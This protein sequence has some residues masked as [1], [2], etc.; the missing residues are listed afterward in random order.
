MI[1]RGAESHPM[2]SF[3]AR[4]PPDPAGDSDALEVLLGSVTCTLHSCG[5][6]EFG[7]GWAIPERALEYHVAY[8]A[9]AGELAVQFDDEE[10]MRIVRPGEVV[11]AGPRERH[12]VLNGGPTPVRL[13]TVH[14]TARIHD[15]VDMPAVYGLARQSR[16]A[17]ADAERIEGIVRQMIDDLDDAAPGSALAANAD[18]GR[19][20]AALWRATVGAAEERTPLA[21]SKARD[22]VRLAPV[23]RVI[24]ERY[25]ERPTVADL[26]GIVHLEPDHFATVFKRVTGTSP[27]AYVAAHRLQRVRTLLAAT[28][29]PIRSIAA[30]TG[31]SDPFY[32]SRAFR[33]AYGMTPT[34][35]RKSRNRPDLP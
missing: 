2:R 25:A 14:F 22:L 10:A 15:V 23:F 19:F 11:L 5:W 30:R 7:R 33:R 28:D 29:E 16:P 3:G 31:F 12:R 1:G 26:A 20:V 8:V 4:R 13:L 18:C 17:P 35:Y 9:V 32:L 24:R 27:H 21:G 6:Y 34:G